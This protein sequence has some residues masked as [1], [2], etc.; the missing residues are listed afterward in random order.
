MCEDTI[1][2]DFLNEIL[3]E[4][5]RVPKV[6]QFKLVCAQNL[7]HRQD[8]FLVAPGE[9]K[10]EIIAAPAI[11]WQ[12]FKQRVI[13]FVVVPSRELMEEHVGFLRYMR[14]ISGLKL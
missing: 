1:S 13:G 3:C 2:L 5:Y 6:E 7:C 14:G 4:G 11:L 12:A 8:L 9:S 10:I